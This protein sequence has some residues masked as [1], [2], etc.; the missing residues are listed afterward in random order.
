MTTVFNSIWEFTQRGMDFLGMILTKKIK[1]FEWFGIKFYINSS[2]IAI[3]V[4][5]IVSGNVS[6]CKVVYVLGIGVSIL[7]HEI[8]HA[9][10]GYL[11]GNPAKEIYL[12]ACG[13]L[14][15]FN[16]TPA[17][18]AKDALMSFA[19]PVVN[20]LVCSLLIWIGI[21]FWGGSFGDWIRILFSQIM[22][23]DLDTDGLPLWLVMLNNIAFVNMS[24]LVFNLL[25][26]FPLDGGRIFRWLGGCFLPSVKAAFMTMLVACA[27]ACL[28]VI[29]SIKTDLII[30]VNLPDF[31]VTCLIAIC[32]LLG[33]F[34]EF[35]R[36]KLRCEAEAGS[37]EA[38][39]DLREYFNEEVYSAWRR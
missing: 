22:G 11:I 4:C 7:L 30:E 18:T 27:L 38:I 12:L 24:M 6:L 33:S 29:Q 1:M 32:I 19:G 8:G 34:A 3:P 23:D 28:I 31:G 26:A 14:T 37:P 10:A 39:E 36:T 13:G 35:W 21:V 9:L 2:V 5:M 25:P 17:S 15:F 20:G 16:H